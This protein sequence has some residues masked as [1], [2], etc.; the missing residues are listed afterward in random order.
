MTSTHTGEYINISIPQSLL[1]QAHLDDA[2]PF[3]FELCSD[4]LLIRPKKSRTLNF[5]PHS[6]WPAGMFT[7][8]H[9]DSFPD[10]AELRADLIEPQPIDL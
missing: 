9:D 1:H 10:V 2:G 5:T 8:Y 3:S 4:G 7:P 6:S